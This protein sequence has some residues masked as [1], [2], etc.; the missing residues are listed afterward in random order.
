MEKKQ[1]LR[2]EFE[3]NNEKYQLFSNEN[4]GDN[5]PYDLQAK[6][7]FDFFWNHIEQS[8][9]ELVSKLQMY[10]GHIENDGVTGKP[11]NISREE[12]IKDMMDIITSN[13]PANE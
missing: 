8:H 13:T 3:A 6:T 5:M 9:K 7:V 4:Y 12:L 2:E 11:M 1:Q 10:I